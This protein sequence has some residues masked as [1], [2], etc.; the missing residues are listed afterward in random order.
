M[1]SENPNAPGEN[2]TESINIKNAALKESP[3]TGPGASTTNSAPSL[4]DSYDSNNRHRYRIPRWLKDIL[5]IGA[6][7]AGIAYAVVTY[8]MWRDSHR[9]FVIDERCW[10]SIDGNFPN[11]IKEGIPFQGSILVKNTG[12]TTAKQ[13]VSEWIIAILRSADSVSFDYSQ[14]RT[15]ELIGVLPPN[16]F[17]LFTASKPVDQYTAAF[18]TKE[19][20]EDLLNGRTYL[21]LYGRG[22]YNDVF[23]NTHW[24]HFCGWKDYYP[25]NASYKAANCVAYTDTGDGDLP[26]PDIK[27]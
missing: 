27:K 5:E 2:N 25:G 4:K 26:D 1:A 13:I 16:G 7:V 19:Q 22:R 20:A 9:N 6:L 18:L 17:T 15:T 23:G 24:F 8:F 14:M 11:P 21:V 12:K 3:I 10:I